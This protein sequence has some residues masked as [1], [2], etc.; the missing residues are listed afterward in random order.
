M[1]SLEEE[2]IEDFSTK[3]FRSYGIG[4]EEEDNGVLLLLAKEDREVRIE[5]GY[6]LEGAI[7]DAKAGRILDLFSLPYFEHDKWDEGILN[8]FKE[9]VK[10]VKWEYSAAFSEEEIDIAENEPQEYEAPGFFETWTGWFV[11]SIPISLVMGIILYKMLEK[12]AKYAI[13]VWLVI[14]ALFFIIRF[15][16]WSAILSLFV[17]SVA[18]LFGYC[19]VSPDSDS[20][21]SYYYGSSSSSSSRSSSSGS[22]SSHS[23]GGGASRKF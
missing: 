10:E 14:V 6:G 21:S 2:S 15:S 9:I 7:N 19:A 3:L 16:V 23:G 5:V 12:H 18:A 22:R 13:W 1:D 20:E 17:S 11:I 8:G 4:S